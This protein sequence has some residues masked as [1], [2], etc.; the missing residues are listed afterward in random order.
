MKL[1]I[2]DDA[3]QEL[4]KLPVSARS[5][6]WRDLQSILID[7]FRRT[8]RAYWKGLELFQEHFKWCE[9]AAIEE[10]SLMHPKSR[11]MHWAR[12]RKQRAEETTKPH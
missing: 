1:L 2:T 11:V 3:G 6:L 7:H 5:G 8:S 9:V 10:R 12:L 4:F